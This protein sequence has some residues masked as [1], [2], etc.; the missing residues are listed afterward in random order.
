MLQPHGGLFCA[1]IPS[2]V[3]ARAGVWPRPQGWTLSR[4]VHTQLSPCV[5]KPTAQRC[6]FAGL[7][8][9]STVPTQQ[10]LRSPHTSPLAPAATDSTLIPWGHGHRSLIRETS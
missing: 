6:P 1:D 3:C 8:S 7:G 9:A 4:T 10:P 2:S 5:P